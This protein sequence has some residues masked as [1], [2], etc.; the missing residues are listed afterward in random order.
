MKLKIKS[1][2]YT[3]AFTF[4]ALRML[5]DFDLAVFEELEKKPFKTLDVLYTLFYAAINHSKSEFYDESTCEELLEDYFNQE[6]SDVGEL[7]KQ[8]IDMLQATSFFKQ[9]Q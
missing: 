6:G 3:L 9:K 5:D 7:T 2:T 8:L 1:K 4:R